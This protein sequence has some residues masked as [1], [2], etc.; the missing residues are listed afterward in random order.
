MTC[1]HNL[2]RDRNL[3]Q[4]ATCVITVDLHWH[5]MTAP[6]PQFTWGLPPG[7]GCSVGSNKSAVACAHHC[8]APQNSLTA[9]N[10]AVL[11]LCIPPPPNAWRHCLFYCLHSL[12]SRMSYSWNHMVHTKPFLISSFHLV[13]C[14]QFFPCF[15]HGLAVLFFL[16]LNSISLSGYITIYL[17]VDPRKH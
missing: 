4:S 6:S 7:G 17:A 9:P 14:I 12:L 5:I 2:P 10:S 16:A 11:R 3:H 13:M 1:V 15:F 8:A